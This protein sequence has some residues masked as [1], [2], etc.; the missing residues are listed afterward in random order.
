MLD[1]RGYVNPFAPGATEAGQR[2]GMTGEIYTEDRRGH[3]IEALIQSIRKGSV[4]AVLEL[5]CLAPGG[6][7]PQK[8]RRLLTERVEAI[9]ARG[10]S[11]LELATG[12]SSKKGHLPRMLLTAYE[13]IATSGRAR[14][15][16]RTGRPI[17]HTLDKHERE[18]VEGIWTSRRYRNDD[19][20]VVAIEKRTGKRLKRGWLRTHF[21]S[22]HGRQDVAD[23]E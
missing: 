18:V 4:V 16:D 7:R 3:V 21:G 12:Y 22:P 2:E 19:E 20:R 14:K 17:K 8:R 15:R 13:Q 1:V 9:K 10:G 23:E 6:F 5:Y 11:I